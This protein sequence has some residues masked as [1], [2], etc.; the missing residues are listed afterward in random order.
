MQ[1]ACGNT[2]VHTGFWW[3]KPEGKN[4]L[5]DKGVDGRIILECTFEK[6]EGG[7]D[8]IDLA[9]IQTSGGLL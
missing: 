5:E 2:E 6:W 8:W 3:G 9:V 7:M 4:D 1:H